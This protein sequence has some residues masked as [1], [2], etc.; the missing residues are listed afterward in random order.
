MELVQQYLEYLKAMSFHLFS[1]NWKLL[2][3]HLLERQLETWATA[4]SIGFWPELHE[5]YQDEPQSV[6]WD[7]LMTIIHPIVNY[8][9][10]EDGKKITEEQIMLSDDLLHDKFAVRAF[11]KTTMDHLRA[12]G[13]VPKQII[14]FCDNCTGQYKSKDPFQFISESNIPPV[15]LFFGAHH[16]K[17]LT[18]GVARRAVKSRK[19]I[20]RNAEE[21]TNCCKEKFE[22]NA[23]KPEGVCDARRLKL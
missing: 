17:G 1:C 9:K 3:V 15:Q 22:K 13:I 20:I 2:T 4:A 10:T 5:C 12:K 19:T 18:D 23:F 16:G 7:H 6:H 11:E 8:Y 21:F 14:Q